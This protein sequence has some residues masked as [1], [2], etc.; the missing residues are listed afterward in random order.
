MSHYCCSV[1]P[2]EP[3][4]VIHLRGGRYKKIG[5]PLPAAAELGRYE[6][7]VRNVARYLYLE[8][9]PGRKRVPRGSAF[10]FELRISAV[11]SGSVVPVLERSGTDDG[12][13]Q[14]RPDWFERSRV[15]INEALRGFNGPDS[16]LVRSFPVECLEDFTA[17]GRSLADD[18]SIEFSDCGVDDQVPAVLNVGVRRRILQFAKLGHLDVEIPLLGRVTGLRTSPSQFDFVLAESGKRLVAGYQDSAL[19][20][21]MKSVLGE[22]DRAPLVSLTAV[23]KQ[24]PDGEIVEILDVLAV[25]VTLPDSWRERISYLAELPQGWLDDD[26]IA[27]TTVAIDQTERLLLTCLDELIPRPGIFPT[28]EGGTQLEWQSGHSETEVRV[29]SDGSVHAL[30]FST[31]TDDEREADYDRDADL[32]TIAAFVREGL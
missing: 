19:W 1:S 10:D 12:L 3:F 28:P 14:G 32:L 16:G 25:E 9:H 29:S 6:K 4:G 31:T 11:N 17:F 20:E 26:S 30:W 5:L 7:L 23:A 15:L 24:A 21:E 18:E 22:G 8:D 13:F 2:V 27:P